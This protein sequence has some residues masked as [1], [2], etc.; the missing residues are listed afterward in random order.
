MSEYD[1]RSKPVNDLYREA[2]D[3]IFRK[4]PAQ[5]NN[6]ED[7]PLAEVCAPNTCASEV[8]P[9]VEALRTPLYDYWID[10]AAEVTKEQGDALLPPTPCACPPGRCYSRPWCRIQLGAK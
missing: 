3:R 2:Y 9:A 6:R 8:C 5:P 4:T 10:E 1:A 7:C